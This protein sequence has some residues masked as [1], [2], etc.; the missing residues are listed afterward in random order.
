MVDK[1][2]HH[3]LPPEEVLKKVQQVP[4]GLVEKILEKRHR[5][6]LKLH[7]S[8]PVAMPKDD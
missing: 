1:K 2:Q 6:E 7:G 8:V 4:E 3:P 5:E